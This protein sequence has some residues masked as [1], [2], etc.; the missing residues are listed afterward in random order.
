[1]DN[2]IVICGYPPKF[3]VVGKLPQ[4]ETTTCDR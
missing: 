2:Q 4:S 3:L 1:M